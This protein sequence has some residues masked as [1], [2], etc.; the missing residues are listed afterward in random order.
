MRAGG[1][2]LA[3]GLMS[4]TSADGIDAALVEFREDG[5]GSCALHLVRHLHR[6]FAPAERE[7]ILALCTPRAR[8]V[9]AAAMHVRLGRLFGEAAADVM[10]EAGVGPDEVAVVGSHGQSVAHY[11]HGL[12]QA[13]GPGFT[14]QI[15]DPA[16]VAAVCGVPVVSDFRAHDVALGGE[17][18]PLVP[19]F[20]RAVFASPHEDRVLLNIGGIAN[21]TVL[22]AKAP[23][24][25]VVAFDTG[26]GNMLLDAAA[27][28]LSGGREA[29]DRDGAWAARGRPH[30]ALLA[31]WRRHPYY[32]LPPPKSTGR[33]AFGRAYARRLLGQA[34]RAGVGAE[35]VMATLTALVAD[36]IADG[37]R[38]AAPGPVALIAAGGGVR[39]RTLMDA[40]AARLTLVRPWQRT[41]DYG[42]PAQAKEAMA[43]AFLAWQFVHGRA[44][45]LTSVTGARAAVPL[46]S[47]TPARA[48][49]EGDP[50]TGEEGR[51]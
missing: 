7:R 51:A 21:I 2:N 23:A 49:A 50:W 43:F 26:P 8:L 42:V 47:W 44:T 19:A 24:E 32:A 40:L 31:R 1:R 10:R 15:G 28:E 13:G 33:E 3:V 29:F 37:V 34:R 46:G 45:N 6:P 36:T 25:A 27:W 16:T 18:A 9:D 4:G 14:V 5:E 11:P 41:D 38:R 30:D 35:D 48:W 22:R 17:G 20:D 39:N 12:P